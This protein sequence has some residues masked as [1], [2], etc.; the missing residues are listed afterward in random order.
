ML[1]VFVAIENDGS[2]VSKKDYPWLVEDTSG[3]WRPLP[4]VSE[5][6]AKE[7]AFYLNERLATSSRLAKALDEEIA[8]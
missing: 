5:E 4:S 7:F 8:S 3:A 6:R 2:I 1:E